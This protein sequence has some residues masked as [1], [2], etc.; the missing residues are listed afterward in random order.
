MPCTAALPVPPLKS[1][2]LLRCRHSKVDEQN[3]NHDRSWK[4]TSYSRLQD[5]MDQK[6]SGVES[7]MKSCLQYS[8][9]D[10][11]KTRPS[12]ALIAHLLVA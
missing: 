1:Q 7:G 12:S 8:L 2:T 3:S 5:W 4:R 10:L 6:E 11:D 9:D